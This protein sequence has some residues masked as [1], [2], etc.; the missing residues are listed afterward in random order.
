MMGLLLRL[1]QGFFLNAVIDQNAQSWREVELENKVYVVLGLSEDGDSY[2]L[3]V[4]PQ[5]LLQD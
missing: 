4:L 3:Q 2:V 5:W 1:D